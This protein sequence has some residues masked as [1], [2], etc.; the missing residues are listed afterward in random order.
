[1]QNIC[2]NNKVTELTACWEILLFTKLTTKIELRACAQGV[3]DV[4]D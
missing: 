1:M 4:D 3:D 2:E